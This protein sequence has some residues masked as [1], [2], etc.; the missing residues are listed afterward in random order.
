MAEGLCS[1]LQSRLCRFESD[2]RLQTRAPA[3]RCVDQGHA[4]CL[5]SCVIFFR[6]TI[7]KD[8][9]SADFEWPGKV[10]LTEAELADFIGALLRVRRQ[11]LPA[12]G[13]PSAGTTHAHVRQLQ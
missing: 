6:A 7:Q 2:S 5:R 11:L 3:S 4:D 12:P 13:N 9:R 10:N 8:Q 1:G